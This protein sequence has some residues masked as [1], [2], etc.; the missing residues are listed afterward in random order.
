MSLLLLQG[1]LIFGYLFSASV[2][3]DSPQ[4]TT[5]TPMR[6]VVF[7]YKNDAYRIHFL[8]KSAQ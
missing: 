1:L 6:T 2:D 7:N 8:L 4:E 3:N 5:T